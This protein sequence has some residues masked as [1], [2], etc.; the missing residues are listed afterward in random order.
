[1]AGG[2]RPDPV[3]GSVQ[4]RCQAPGLARSS[5]YY[6]PR[7]ESAENLALMRLLDEEFTL[8][9]FKGVLDLLGIEYQV[10]MQ[11]SILSL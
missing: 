10:I 11:K 8:H 5:F 4:A 7:D 2:Q 1:M 3:G 6:Q 9:N